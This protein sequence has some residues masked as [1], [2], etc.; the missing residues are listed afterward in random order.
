MLLY[1]HLLL[2][3]LVVICRTNVIEQSKTSNV[4]NLFNL[5][6]MLENN[7]TDLVLVEGDIALPLESSRTAFIQAP[8]W[9]NGIVPFE[10]DGIFSNNQINTIVSAMNTISQETGNCIRFVARGNNPAWLRI[11]SGQG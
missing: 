10:I 5:P 6:D 7:R 1:W 9:P 2:S 11:H 8:R 4:P 3:G